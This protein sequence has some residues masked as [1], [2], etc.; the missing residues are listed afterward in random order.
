MGRRPRLE[1]VSIPSLGG[2]R[3]DRHPSFSL[4]FLISYIYYPYSM[5]TLDDNSNTLFVCLFISVLCVWELRDRELKFWLHCFWSKEGGAYSG[6]K[7]NGWG[8][9]LDERKV[10]VW[11]E[12]LRNTHLFVLSMSDSTTSNQVLMMCLGMMSKG[13]I[14]LALPGSTLEW[15]ARV[16][17]APKKVGSCLGMLERSL[18]D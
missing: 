7:L 3:V 8:K 2:D 10:C 9:L 17:F 1:S 13:S 12:A 4:F 11:K 16:L 6:R 15:W 14:C 18:E 5:L